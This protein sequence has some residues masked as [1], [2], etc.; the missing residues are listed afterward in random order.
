MSGS[1]WNLWWM[2]SLSFLKSCMQVVPEMLKIT[3]S[4]SLSSAMHLPK[5]SL[6]EKSSG[7]CESLQLKATHSYKGKYA[8]PTHLPRSSKGRY[9]LYTRCW[10]NHYLSR[11][12]F[13]Q[14]RSRLWPSSAVYHSCSCGGQQAVAPHCCVSLWQGCD[15][16]T[17][18]QA[19]LTV[20]NI[21]LSGFWRHKPITVVFQ[22]MP[23]FVLT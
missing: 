23:V 14:S 11:K 20:V 4:A 16:C 10:R 3:Y 15:A 6:H 19:L 8:L 22:N 17:V 12:S 21:F 13:M 9:T 1:P 5:Y 2:Q 18:S 7:I